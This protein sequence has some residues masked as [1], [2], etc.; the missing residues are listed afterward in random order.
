MGAFTGL[1]VANADNPRETP[2]T[3]S[4]EPAEPVEPYDRAVMV[5]RAA[6]GILALTMQMSLAQYVHLDSPPPE[7]DVTLFA[8]D[9]I[10][11][12]KITLDTMLVEMEGL[13]A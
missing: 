10:T 7:Y 8:M 3:V 1:R 13:P 11:Q 9:A 5:E 2:N 6:R 12:A 4:P